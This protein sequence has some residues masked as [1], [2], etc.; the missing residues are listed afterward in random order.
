LAHNIT[1]VLMFCKLFSAF[2]SIF[3][4]F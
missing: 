2:F 1:T 4:V 3:C